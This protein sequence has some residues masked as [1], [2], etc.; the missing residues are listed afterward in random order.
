MA[1]EVCDCDGGCSSCCPPFVPEG[2]SIEITFYGH[3]GTG[4]S[5]YRINEAVSRMDVRDKSKWT[6]KYEREIANKIAK[7]LGVE[8]CHA[9]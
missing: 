9:V 7:M 2:I 6:K 4:R 1:T 3:Q 8:A 5:E